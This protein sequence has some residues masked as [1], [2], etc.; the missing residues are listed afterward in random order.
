M[1]ESIDIPTAAWGTFD[2]ILVNHKIK[3]ISCKPSNSKINSNSNHKGL[4]LKNRNG[5]FLNIY[6]WTKYPISGLSCCR[7]NSEVMN[8]MLADKPLNDVRW[9][10]VEELLEQRYDWLKDIF[11]R[12][13]PNCTAH[14]SS[15]SPGSNLPRPRLSRN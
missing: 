4:N 13:A 11:T 15:L 10:N 12:I 2:L 1:I 3:I 5:S 14:R 7:A 8:K 9:S 6:L